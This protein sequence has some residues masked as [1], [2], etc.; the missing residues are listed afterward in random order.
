MIG[1]EVPT[2]VIGEKAVWRVP[3]WIGFPRHGSHT[4]GFVDV[5][6]ENGQMDNT[7]ERKAEIEQRAATI[8]ASLPAYA[9][10]HTPDEYL[11]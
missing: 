1:A 3:V 6:V 8:G 5:D 11:A 4:L 10:Q 7:P 9:P 2:L